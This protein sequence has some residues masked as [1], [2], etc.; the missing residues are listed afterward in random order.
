MK[1]S[2]KKIIIAFIILAL[3]FSLIPRTYH[4]KDGGTVRH[5]AVLFQIISWH[6]MCSEKN[7]FYIGLEVKVLGITVYNDAK[8]ITKK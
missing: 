4:L 7:T 6:T 5:E 3:V 2:K 8:E 1:R